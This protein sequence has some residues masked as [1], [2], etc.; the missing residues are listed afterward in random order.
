MP[1]AV[2]AL[3]EGGGAAPAIAHWALPTRTGRASLNEGGGAAPA[4]AV[5]VRQ[6]PQQPLPRS[7][8][9]GAPP[10]QSRKFRLIPYYTAVAQ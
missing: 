5:G 9:A 1:A 8:K 7:M 6:Q 2:P 4:I 3:N 10:P